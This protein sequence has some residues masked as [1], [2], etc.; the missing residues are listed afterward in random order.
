MYRDPQVSAAGAT[1]F[2]LLDEAGAAGDHTLVP[3]ESLEIPGIEE[4][5]V[6][7]LAAVNKC[8]V[9]GRGRG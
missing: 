3:A 8:A 7:E 5:M 4:A 2:R 1:D 9:A 6:Q